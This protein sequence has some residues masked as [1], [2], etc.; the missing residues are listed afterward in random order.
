MAQYRIVLVVVC[1]ITGFIAE[2]LKHAHYGILAFIFYAIF[3]FCFSALLFSF[4]NK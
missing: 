1:F 3:I 4:F 2:T